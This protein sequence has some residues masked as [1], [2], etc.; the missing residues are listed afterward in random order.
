[1]PAAQRGADAFCRAIGALRA[2]QRPHGAETARAPQS[3]A[4]PVHRL[5]RRGNLSSARA[6]ASAAISRNASTDSF[7]Q[8]PSSC[9]RTPQS[10]T[11][12]PP[13][14]KPRPGSRAAKPHRGSARLRQTIVDR[15]APE[16]VIA[17]RTG[18]STAVGAWRTYSCTRHSSK[19]RPR[20]VIGFPER[21][22][23]QSGSLTMSGSEHG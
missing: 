14:C 7:T 13:R 10:L 12:W 1:M 3:P 17:L 19:I 6:I 20:F 9:G 11:I 18:S 15:L 4:T 2:P 16:S 23:G 5:D 22:N 21:R 8:V